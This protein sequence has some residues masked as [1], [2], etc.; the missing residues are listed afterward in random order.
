MSRYAGIADLQLRLSDLY[1]NI[2]RRL[3]GSAMTEEAQADLDAAEAEI[4]GIVGTR[5]A[6][7]VESGAALP[8]LKAWAVTL[9]EELAWS[10]SGK[11]D[12][13][14]NVQTRAET[15]RANLR[16]IAAGKM[17]LPGASQNESSGGGSVVAIAGNDPVFGRDRMEGY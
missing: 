4:D 10:R 17:L 11:G 7:P 6:V 13:P 14:K 3:D 5:Y 8:L 12:L 15:V 1:G 16:L 2:Y 9:A